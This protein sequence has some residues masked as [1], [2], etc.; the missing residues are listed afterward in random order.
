MTVCGPLVQ[1]S[2][3]VVCPDD[4]FIICI[5]C[6]VTEGSGLRWD[7]GKTTVSYSLVDTAG[8]DRDRPP[9]KVS[10]SRIMQD[11][12]RGNFR[13]QLQVHSSDLRE[14]IK[15]SGGQLK[16]ACRS[17]SQQENITAL[18]SGKCL[19]IEYSCCCYGNRS[20]CGNLYCGVYYYTTKKLIAWSYLMCS[21]AGH[22]YFACRYLERAQ[23]KAYILS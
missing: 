22:T 3:I 8:I 15:K 4:N 17:T 1:D 21:L 23:G 18:L 5:Q 6:D 11:G 19:L 16:I 12:D 7:Y 2:A 13:S 14:S 10:L 20:F 9:I